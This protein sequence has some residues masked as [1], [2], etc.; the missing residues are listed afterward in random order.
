M[1]CM[2]ELQPIGKL[3]KHYNNLYIIIKVWSTDFTRDTK[4]HANLFS[5]VVCN[6]L[7]GLALVVVVVV[8]LKK[9]LV[10][11]KLTYGSYSGIGQNDP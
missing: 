9:K 11:S 1:K 10:H 3:L 4:Q 6:L 5:V 7:P 2:Q 8:D